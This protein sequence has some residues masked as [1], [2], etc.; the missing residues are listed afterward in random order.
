[1]KKLNTSELLS[2][3]EVTRRIEEKTGQALSPQAI[4]SLF[5]RRRLDTERCPVIGRA[6]VIPEDYVPAVENAVACMR[7]RGVSPC[8]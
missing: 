3:S 7:K 1:M 5:Y 4:S 6:R 8:G 2:I